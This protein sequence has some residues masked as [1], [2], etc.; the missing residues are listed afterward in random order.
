[1][2]GRNSKKAFRA[3]CIHPDVETVWAYTE[4]GALQQIERKI[5]DVI[6]TNEGS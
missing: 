1:M 5:D 6:F 4:K 3:S 2:R